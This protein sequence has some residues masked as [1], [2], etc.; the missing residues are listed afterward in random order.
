[1]SRIGHCPIPSKNCW[2]LLSHWF[3]LA[4]AEIIEISG[5]IAHKQ[6][7]KVGNSSSHWDIMLM[8][9]FPV[10]WTNPL[11]PNICSWRSMTFD[12][13]WRKDQDSRTLS[14]ASQSS[15]TNRYSCPLWSRS[16]R[17]P[18]GHAKHGERIARTMGPPQVKSK[19]Q[20]Q[21][22]PTS[23][24]LSEK[25]KAELVGRCYLCKEPGHMVQN[26]PQGNKIK[27][28]AGKPPGTS[29]LNIEF[30][31][32][33]KVLES[34]PLGMVEVESWDEFHNWHANYPQWDQLGAWTQSKI[35][36]CYAM[37]AEYILTIQQPYPRDKWYCPI[38]LPYEQFNIYKYVSGNYLI[39]N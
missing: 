20:S 18:L 15:M 2:L 14:F 34:L 8:P 11:L 4:Q 30:D 29:N 38:D 35:G 28:T 7:N 31:D 33:V 32:R 22:L 23:P 25:E 9:R 37:M 17:P 27:S 24:V 21:L 13:K 36:D 39:A 6:N 1:M 5:N 26:C 16:T 10:S 19:S 12:S 3:L